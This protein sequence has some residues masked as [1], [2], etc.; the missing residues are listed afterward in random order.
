MA[1]G[2]ATQS[3]QLPPGYEDAKPVAG[4]MAA[5]TSGSGVSLPPGYEDAKPIKGPAAPQQPTGWDGEKFNDDILKGV[6]D[7][8][9]DVWNVAKKTFAALTPGMTP[10]RPLGSY[11]TESVDAVKGIWNELPPVKLLDSVKQTLPVINAYEKARASGASVSDAIKASNDTAMQ[12]S[13]AVIT[14]KRAADAFHENPTRESARALTDATALAASM[15]GGPEIAAPVEETE[16][17]TAPTVAARVNPFRAAPAATSKIEPA[18][19]ARTA[20]A[21]LPA[22]TPEVTT[23]QAAQQT[24]QSAIDA[25]NATQAN[26]DSGL[27]S[28][29]QKHAGTNSI[30]APAAGTASRDLITNNGNALVNAG[31]ADYKI[32]DKFTN[33]QFTNAQQELENAQFELQ[34]K[35]GTTE[36]NPADLEANVARAQWNVEK[37]FDDAVKAGMPPETAETARAKFRTGQATLDAGNAVRMANKVRGAAGE[38][39]TDLNALENRWTALYDSGRLQQAFGEKGAQDA[40]AQVKAAREMGDTFSAMPPTE[41]QALRKL[42]ADNTT[43]GKFG[44]NTDWVKVRKDFSDLPNRNAQFSNVP[45]VEKFINDQAFYQRLQSTAKYVAGAVIGGSLAS[46]GWNLAH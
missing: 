12:H 28:I 34:R 16:A 20:K 32:L 1:D 24:A 42:I 15:F 44:T 46:E 39:A 30:P 37:L 6:G 5:Q 29:A 45:M 22:G 18:V 36:A 3:V 33:G 2:T 17:A 4:P 25:R 11:P 26:L 27:Q 13:A 38:R 35:A 31:K 14:A 8:A 9:G 10:G 23:E 43:T 41:S 40:L 19:A 21:G 7:A